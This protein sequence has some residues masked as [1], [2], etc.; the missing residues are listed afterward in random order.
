MMVE[1]ASELWEGTHILFAQVLHESM[2]V[3]C[4]AFM[5]I[6][7][8]DSKYFR[9]P[10]LC[11]VCKTYRSTGDSM[12]QTVVTEYLLEVR[13]QLHLALCLLAL[14]NMKTTRNNLKMK[15]KREF[16]QSATYMRG[17]LIQ[18]RTECFEKCIKL[19]IICNATKPKYSVCISSLQM[20][21][22]KEIPSAILTTF[23]NYCNKINLLN[24]QM[25][26][27]LVLFNFSKGIFDY[28]TVEMKNQ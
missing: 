15:F 14:N 7:Q 24:Y 4:I 19:R 9:S 27:T 21:Q 17:W 13:Y 8:P 11:Y 28:H 25:R 26:I 16:K 18:H 6:F 12:H 22:L 1:V 23:G 10:M 2:P 20:C 5:Q 3:W